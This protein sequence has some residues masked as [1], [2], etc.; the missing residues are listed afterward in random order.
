MDTARGRI[1]FLGANADRHLYNIAGDSWS[2][3]TLTGAN[4]ADV[5]GIGAMGMVYVP[6]LDRFLVR[7]AGSGGTVYQIHPTTFEVTTWS[8]TDGASVP[9]TVNGP[10]NK[11]LYVPRL[12]GVVYVPVYAGNAWFLRL[13]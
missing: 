9:A 10:Y 7:R 8:T 2:T 12:G 5:D 3:V 1:F 11:F 13:H 4:A 6:E